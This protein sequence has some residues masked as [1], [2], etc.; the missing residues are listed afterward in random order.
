MNR[1]MLLHQTL[2]LIYQESESASLSREEPARKYFRVCGPDYFCLWLS[3]STAVVGEKQRGSDG[4]ERN[5]NCGFADTE[6]WVS[7]YCSCHTA[8]D[9]LILTIISIKRILCRT[10]KDSRIW[11]WG[12]WVLNT[13]PESWHIHR[14]LKSIFCL[15]LKLQEQ[16]S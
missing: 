1:L 14:F 4:C 5:L 7:H 16:I 2:S 3:N 11:P 9:W 6:V 8:L 13:D 10:D 12:Q 15:I